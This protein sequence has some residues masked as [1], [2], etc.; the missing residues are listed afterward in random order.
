[1]LTDYT[2]NLKT[3]TGL[4]DKLK[5]AGPDGFEHEA[6][7][8]GCGPRSTCSICRCH[9]GRRREAGPCRSEKGF[10]VADGIVTGVG[11]G[12]SSHVSTVGSGIA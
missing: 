3:N 8:T 10:Q 6:T 2:A 12:V 7:A 11:G 9:P 1:M 5:A 4:K